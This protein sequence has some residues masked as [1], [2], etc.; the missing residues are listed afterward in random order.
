MILPLAASGEPIDL[1]PL[2]VALAGAKTAAL[3]N[4]ASLKV[5]RLIVPAGKDV[6]EHTA[7]GDITVQCLEG[8]V[9]FA[10]GGVTRRLEAGRML[11]LAAGTPHALHGVEDASVLVTIVLR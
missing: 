3:V 5:T 8:A 2:G 4:S 11:Y 7:P 6:P 10:A 9:D 1:S